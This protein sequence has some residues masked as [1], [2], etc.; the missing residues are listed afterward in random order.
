MPFDCMYMRLFIHEYYTKYFDSFEDMVKTA[1]KEYPEIKKMCD[2]F[3][4]ELMS[5]T[6]KLG[7]EYQYI[8]T[9]AYRPFLS[10]AST[11]SLGT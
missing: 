7:E 6:G 4:A 5:E 10:F 2:K 11:P 8:T 3:D 1:I 9:L